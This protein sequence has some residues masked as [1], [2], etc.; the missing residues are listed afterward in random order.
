M[1]VARRAEALS[2]MT[3]T[4]VTGRSSVSSDARCGVLSRIVSRYWKFC[5]AYWPSI[6]VAKPQATIVNVVLDMLM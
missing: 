1:L 5:T 2:S 4:L 3:R 6:P